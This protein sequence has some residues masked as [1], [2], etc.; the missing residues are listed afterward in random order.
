MNEEAKSLHLETL[1]S[2][3]TSKNRKMVMILGVA[4]S[5]A[6]LTIIIA[7][8]FVIYVVRRMKNGDAVE[9]WEL[10][11]ESNTI[12]AVK[13]I[14]QDSEEGLQQFMSEIETIGRL[15]HKNIVQLRG[16]CRKSWKCVVG[17]GDE[18]EGLLM[19]HGENP[20]TTRVVGT[21][22][23]LAPELTLT[24]KP[25]A[26]SDVFAFGALLLEVGCGRRPFE[27]KALPEELILVD[28][29]KDRWGAGRVLEVV[30]SKLNWAFDPV[31]ALVKLRLGLMCSSDVP[32]EA[33][34]EASGD[35]FGEGHAAS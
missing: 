5:F 6:I 17:F 13:R 28:W 10:E 35:V 24:G 23:Y 29:V 19:D 26:S 2:L 27:P 12:I 8:G 9:P 31:Q 14:K 25:T 20:N 18:W 34:Y 16:W 21:L 30:D 32:E 1:P 4:V 3:P 22:G 33:Q 15:R 7:I 11:V